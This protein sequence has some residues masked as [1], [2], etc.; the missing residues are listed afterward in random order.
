[1]YFNTYQV[2]SIEVLLKFE[3]NLPYSIGANDLYDNLDSK[4]KSQNLTSILI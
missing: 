1:M 3:S 4:S 2:E